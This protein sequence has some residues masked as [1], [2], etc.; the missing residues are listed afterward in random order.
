MNSSVSTDKTYSKMIEGSVT[1][2]LDDPQLVAND[3][4]ANQYKKTVDVSSYQ[5]IIKN[6]T[7]NEAVFFENNHD[8]ASAAPVDVTFYVV[9]TCYSIPS[10]GGSKTYYPT[11]MHALNATDTLAEAPSAL[12]LVAPVSV[13]YASAKYTVSTGINAAWS[14]TQ[15]VHEITNDATVGPTVTLRIPYGTDDTTIL[16]Y[17][18]GQ[19]KNL[20]FTN[21]GSKTADNANLKNEVVIHAGKELTNNGS[22]EIAGTVSGGNGGS[23]VNSMVNGSHAQI[24]MMQNAGIVCETASGISNGGNLTCYGYISEAAENNGSYVDV[25]N[26][27]TTLVFSMS[28]HRGGTKFTGIAALA[29]LGWEH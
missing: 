17:T 6:E 26:G 4:G 21:R 28:E 9:S 8:I 16:S 24:K 1:V 23:A 14:D 10:G 18:N 27:T 19:I 2:T 29:A 3:T 13:T 25:Q 11:L 12:I 20:A 22:I 7:T 15:Y 5:T